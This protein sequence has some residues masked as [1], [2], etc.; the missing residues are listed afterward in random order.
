MFDDPDFGTYIDKLI[1]HYM[2]YNKLDLNIMLVRKNFK[3][4]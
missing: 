1:R 4:I 3:K 2:Y